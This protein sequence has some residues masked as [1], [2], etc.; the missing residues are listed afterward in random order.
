MVR[1]SVT[2]SAKPHRILVVDD[3]PDLERLVRQRMRRDVRAGR[4]VLDFARNGIEALEKLKREDA[5]DMV[6]SD[7]NMPLM[8][9]L[10]LLQQIPN[11][12][13]DVRA[14]IVSAYGD[15]RNIRIAM[16]RGAFDF[17]TKPIDFKDLRVTIARTLK[18][19]EE[20]RE[21]LRSRDRLVVLENELEVARRMQK[22]I[23]PTEFP[24]LP[25]VG[26]Y[27]NMQPARAIGGDFYDVANLGGGRFGVAIADVSGKGIPAALFMMSSRTLLK[28]AAVG[29]S[30]SAEVLQE[31]NRVLS[32]DNASMMFVTLL[33]AV[34]DAATG[35]FSYASGGHEPPLLVRADGGCTFLPLTDGLAL[36]VMEDFEYS[37]SRAR[38]EPGDTMLLYTDGVTDAQNQGGEHFGAERLWDL[39]NNAPPA[40]EKDAV[41]RIFGAVR[42][43]STNAEQFDDITC[44][45]V[46]RRAC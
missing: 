42:K 41:D 20:W 32:R 45:A 17:I 39:F 46:S 10:T 12:N 14:V 27:A 8:D 1:R 35:K 21:A 2:L 13:P 34:C 22:S 11:V 5:F 15:M 25:G 44:V 16:N 29:G 18:N 43:F 37:A 9:G 36:G 19:L 3:E 24:D 31:T 23:L 30:T 28:G 6:L 33:Y 7:I 38:L 26:I 40:D 4:Y